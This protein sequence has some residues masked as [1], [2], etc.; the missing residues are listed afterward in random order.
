L[1]AGPDPDSSITVPYRSAECPVAGWGIN[2]LGVINTRTGGCHAENGT[3]GKAPKKA[4]REAVACNRVPREKTPKSHGGRARD[5]NSV[6]E[7][8]P[9]I[10]SHTFTE[11]R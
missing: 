10:I 3:N 11:I 8:T 6:H 2:R 4:C 1:N 7:V 5:C 9:T